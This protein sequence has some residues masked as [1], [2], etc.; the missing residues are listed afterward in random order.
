MKDTLLTRTVRK[1][2]NFENQRQ[3]KNE[4]AILPESFLDT[5]CDILTVE[6]LSK[7]L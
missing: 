3:I 7:S 4:M 2:V 6:E 1:N 5:L